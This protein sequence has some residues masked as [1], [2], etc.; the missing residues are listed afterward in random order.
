MTKISIVTVTYNCQNVI[1][2]TIKSIIEQTYPD[3][4]YIIIDGA[5]KDNTLKIINKYSQYIDKIISEPDTGIFDAMNKSLNYIT[6][7]Y[8]IFINA[9]D[10]LIN[11][12]IIA[13][14]FEGNTYTEDLIYGDTYIQKQIG[15]QLFKGKDIY[16]QNPTR[17]Q[18]VFNSQGFSH[19]S[20]FTKVSILQE[21][22][23]NLNY[24]LGADYDTT[25]KIYYTGKQRIRYVKY[26]I[27]I[28][29]DR[30]GGASHNQIKKILDE[31][32]QMFSPHKNLSFWLKY[33]NQ[34]YKEKIK[35]FI[36]LLLPNLV[37]KFQEKKY[38]K[39]I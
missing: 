13:N 8:V 18:L 19:Q 33:Y 17:S 39:E 16:S 3:L 24:P 28:F 14:I 38:K 21:V 31:R 35:S 4:E 10:R 29:D 25:A 26:P 22:K 6:G 9:G 37:K 30:F 27:S 23:F 32:I 36:F 12:Q 2:E 7:E 34:I 5:S 1:E 20:L 11:N 15:F